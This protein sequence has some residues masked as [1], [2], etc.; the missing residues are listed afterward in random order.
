ME[1]PVSKEGEDAFSTPLENRDL[2]D[3]SPA[4]IIPE[5]N[6]DPIDEFNKMVGTRPHK[7]ISSKER[8]ELIEK[9][10]EEAIEREIESFPNLKEEKYKQHAKET[11]ISQ[12]NP[13]DDI[14][15]Q[16]E[17][18]KKQIHQ[19]LCDLDQEQI[20]IDESIEEMINGLI[21]EKFPN[22]NFDDYKEIIKNKV[23]EK[24]ENSSEILRK[25][26]ILSQEEQIKA[27]VSEQLYGLEQIDKEETKKEIQRRIDLE[28]ERRLDLEKDPCW[29]TYKTPEQIRKEVEDEITKEVTHMMGPKAPIKANPITHPP[30]KETPNINLSHTSRGNALRQRGTTA[31]SWIKDIRPHTEAE[32]RIY[33][34]SRVDPAK[35]LTLSLATA[36]WQA[37]EV[38]KVSTD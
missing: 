37:S 7:P 19:I 22:S 18:I 38:S 35:Y 29:A 15:V 24:F 23:R 20:D 28:V 9:T 5:I 34:K 32:K 12:T 4:D 30:K 11:A 10:T 3:P 17:A 2:V 6:I 31:A 27:F 26:D 21:Q 14:L 1:L 36:G 13:E 8:E 25:D 33:E 16:H